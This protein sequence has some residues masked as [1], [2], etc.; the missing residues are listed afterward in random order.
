MTASPVLPALPVLRTLDPADRDRIRALAR[1]VA[2]EDAAEALSEATLLNADAACPGDFGFVLIRERDLDPAGEGPAAPSGPGDGTPDGPAGDAGPL[3]VVAVAALANLTGPGGAGASAEVAVHPAWRR[4][5]LGRALIRHV[6]QRYP[7][8]RFWAHGLLPAARA[9]AASLALETVRELWVMSRPAAGITPAD[10]G[11]VRL[12]AGFAWHAFGPGDEQPWLEVNA[13]AFAGHPEQ[14]RITAADLHARMG[15]PW[16][17]PA[18]FLL[19][20]DVSGPDPKLAAFHWTKIAEPGGPG[21]VYVVGVD[22][23]YQGRGLGK[24]ATALGL[25]YLVSRGVPRIEL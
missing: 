5:G 1:A 19:I 21:E 18:G 3:R 6:L 10:P 8:T 17:D 7:Q 2:Q 23:A 13:A 16:F 25:A 20:S 24:A 4:R 15:E 9:L 12:P 14:G 22:P 11:D